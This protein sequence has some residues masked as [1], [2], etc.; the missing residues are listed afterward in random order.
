[1]HVLRKER[2]DEG[3]LQIQVYSMLELRKI[4]HSRAVCRKTNTHEIEQDA[5]E[6]SPEVTVEAVWSMTV[7]NIAEE[8]LS[9]CGK[10]IESI[11]TDQNS[12]KFV[13]SIVMY[14]NSRKLLRAT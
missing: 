12:R 11:V 1:M 3:R 14:Q 8:D 10:F 5:E 9:N 2:T 4:G 7:Q 13:K 6:P